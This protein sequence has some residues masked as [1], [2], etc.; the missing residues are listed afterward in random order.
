MYTDTLSQKEEK[1][2]QE[3]NSGEKI[4]LAIV[5]VPDIPYNTNNVAKNN[6][7]QEN[8]YSAESSH[9]SVQPVGKQHLDNGNYNSDSEV[10]L[11]TITWQSPTLVLSPNKR[12]FHQ[13][14]MAIHHNKLILK[15]KENKN[16]LN[17][18]EDDE[19]QQSVSSD[20]EASQDHISESSDNSSIQEM[21]EIDKVLEATHIESN[22]KSTENNP[23]ESTAVPEAQTES[24]AE[25]EQIANILTEQ[26]KLPVNHHPI[27][28]SNINEKNKKKPYISELTLS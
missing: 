28:D 8:H 13:D 5:P 17:T 2:K 25:W 7:K 4:S 12:K 11:P 21:S 23:N 9:S 22:K 24:D 10:T 1:V 3:V 15:V 27:Q 14:T 16:E 18:Q 19:T 6:E 26:R 20:R